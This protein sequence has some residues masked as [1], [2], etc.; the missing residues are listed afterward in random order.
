MAKGA[1]A[2]SSDKSAKKVDMAGLDH[3]GAP[4]LGRPSPSAVQKVASPDGVPPDDAAAQYQP[5]P[6]RGSADFGGGVSADQ[7]R[8]AGVPTSEQLVGK[9]GS[10]KDETQL[11]LM[12]AEVKLA[13]EDV[14]TAVTTLKN[15]VL[16]INAANSGDATNSLYFS[17]S[18]AK[19]DEVLLRVPISQFEGQLQRTLS[20]GK[21]VDQNIVRQDAVWANRVRAQSNMDD[22]KSKKLGRG[23]DSVGTNAIQQAPTKRELDAA[24]AQSHWATIR[25]IFEQLQKPSGGKKK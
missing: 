8:Q 2:A 4:A 5:S 7:N 19:P 24:R 14:S 1:A 12:A 13:V 22:R 23:A 16:S 6:G 17:N 9:M 20:V 3:L 10:P 15:Q 11:F 18:K 21:L 25:V